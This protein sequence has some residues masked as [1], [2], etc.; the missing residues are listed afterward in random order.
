MSA[1]NVSLRELRL[2][3]GRLL[4]VAGLPKGCVYPVRDALVDAQSLGLDA[5]GA[6]ERTFAQ[7]PGELGRVAINGAGDHTV[8]D[9]AG[10]PSYL[11]APAVLDVLVARGHSGS[12]VVEVAH[13]VEPEL[14]G[15]LAAAAYLYGLDVTVV[16]CGPAM[17]STIVRRPVHPGGAGGSR[18]TRC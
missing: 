13:V 3:V 8:I 2:V 18:A 15:G 9:G 6:L 5:L 4:Y 14:L 12:A 11:V 17:A 7:L 1:T 10:Q 16:A